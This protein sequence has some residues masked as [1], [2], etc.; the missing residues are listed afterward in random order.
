M[1]NQNV[2]IYSCYNL[3]QVD[4]YLSFHIDEKLVGV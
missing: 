3:K 1:Y 4:N 2:S